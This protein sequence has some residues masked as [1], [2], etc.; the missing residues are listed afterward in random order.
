M[1]QQENEPK[2]SVLQIFLSIIAFFY[3]NYSILFFLNHFELQVSIFIISAYLLTVGV[4][5]YLPT[6]IYTLKDEEFVVMRQFS[7]RYFD[8]YSIKIN[9]I[10]VIQ[11]KNKVSFKFWNNFYNNN[12]KNKIYQVT[13][14]E[15]T[16]AFDPTKELIEALEKKIKERK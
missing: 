14:D 4:Y 8:D 1:K 15:M 3:L 13:T 12:R 6:Y 11:E 16:L 9:Q 10:K 7:E 5:R 2:I